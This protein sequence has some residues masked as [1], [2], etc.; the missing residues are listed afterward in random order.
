MSKIS[1]SA[2]TWHGMGKERERY[3]FLFP[4]N[5]IHDN[6]LLDG[7]FE[8]VDNP[9]W[10]K[11]IFLTIQSKDEITPLN[12]ISVI[13][14]ALNLVNNYKLED[15]EKAMIQYIEENLPEKMI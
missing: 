12:D 9:N 5:R 2:G 11:V 4:K 7:D 1:A 3:N 13:Q 14:F 8:T 15:I 6:F 10:P